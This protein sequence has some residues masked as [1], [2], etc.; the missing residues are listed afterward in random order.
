VQVSIDALSFPAIL[1]R[2]Q[3]VQAGTA[4]LIAFVEDPARVWSTEERGA[5]TADQHPWRCEAA[6]R[7]TV[8]TVDGA[9]V[10]WFQIAATACEGGWLWQFAELDAG[11]ELRRLI[12]AAVE[13]LPQAFSITTAQLESPGP[14]FV[15]CNPAFTELTGWAH[16]EALGQTPRVLQGPQTERAVLDQLR[17]C[18]S[19]G[20]NFEGGAVNYHKSG[21]TF[22]NEWNIAAV[23]AQRATHY[24]TTMRDMTASRISSFQIGK[25]ATEWAELVDVLDDAMVMTELDGRIVRCNRAFASMVH[26]EFSELIGLTLAAVLFGDG[27]QE[28]PVAFFQSRPSTLQLD[29]E[30][31]WFT[32][33]GWP[34]SRNREIRAWVH[35]FHNVT[36]FQ[37]ATAQLERLAQA[38]GQA[39][40]G[41][42]VLDASAAIDYANLQFIRM[43]ALSPG[44]EAQAPLSTSSPA[45]AEAL[46]RARHEGTVTI[47]EPRCTAD[48]A[49]LLLELRVVRLVDAH[50]GLTGFLMIAR[51]L[52][53]RERLLQIA[54]HASAMENI[55]H[56]L[57]GLRHELG[58]PVNSVKMALTVLRTHLSE[59]SPEEISRY[60]ERASAELGRIE[61]LLRSLKTFSLYESF[62]L[63]A[64]RLTGFLTMVARLLEPDLTRRGIS[65][66]TEVEGKPAALAD[67][68][69]LHQVLVNLVSNAAD[70]APTTIVISTRLR[71]AEIEL[72]VEDDGCGIPESRMARLFQPFETTKPT[73]TGLGLVLV[74]RLVT[75]MRGTVDITSKVGIRT[76]VTVR[77]GAAS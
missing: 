16:E 65:L 55:G 56:W 38:A 30:A 25:A 14:H 29:G 18:L 74:R 63:T 40:D 59:F 70:A 76:T 9:A 41:I 37:R 62:D 35:A 43:F 15:Y 6:W 77:L 42:A 49:A 19:R 5:L 68:R 28:P 64:V 75:A 69:G 52:S 73:G 47:R 21:R 26:R 46:E 67:P 39:H 24:V 20:E 8:S 32:V 71:D 72:V 3:R 17:A 7:G 54:E 60:V 27:H 12:E 2:A 22:W 4:W 1:M 48:G 50:R 51:D 44:L 33:R 31:G 13:S 61:Y 34:V 23:P 11:H 45:V 10:R 36:L 57:G 58:N 53:E 66:R